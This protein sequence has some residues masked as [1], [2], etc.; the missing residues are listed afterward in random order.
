MFIARNQE[1]IIASNYK[2]AS[3]ACQPG[4]VPGR[5]H[6][7]NVIRAITSGTPSRRSLNPP[8]STSR[9]RSGVDEDDSSWQAEIAPI[10]APTEHGAP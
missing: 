6:L 5:H 4:P 2:E 8:T 9:C 10:N 3:S 7:P 1:V